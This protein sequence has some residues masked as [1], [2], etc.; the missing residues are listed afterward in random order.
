MARALLFALILEKVKQMTPRKKCVTRRSEEFIRDST[1]LR[2]LV[3][4]IYPA[5]FIGLRP[6]GT[7]HEETMTFKLA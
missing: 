5:G 3:V 4:T 7:R 2:R 1:K 6:E